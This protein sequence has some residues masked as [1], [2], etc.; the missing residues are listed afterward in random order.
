[1]AGW[2]VVSEHGIFGSCDDCSSGS[3][4]PLACRAK[5]AWLRLVCVCA[6]V[7]WQALGVPYQVVNIVSG[8]LNNA[9]GKK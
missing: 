9:A 1:M 7:V 5:H 4:A 2:R 3:P 6:R 8:E